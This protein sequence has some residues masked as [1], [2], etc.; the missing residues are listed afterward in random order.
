LLSVE[1]KPLTSRGRKTKRSQPYRG[2][3]IDPLIIC[4][5]RCFTDIKM[6]RGGLVV[7]SRPWS[8]RIPGPKPNSSEYPPCMKPDAY[9]II[10][11]GQTPT[12]WHAEQLVEECAS[13]DVVLAI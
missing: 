12:R 5:F 10:R 13:S 6:G 11:S 4:L 7:R 8:Q 3:I 2:T 9:E 1:K